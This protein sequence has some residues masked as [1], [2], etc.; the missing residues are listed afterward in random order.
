LW[1]FENTA[2]V[3]AG[4][5]A[6]KPDVDFKNR[7]LLFARRTPTPFT[8]PTPNGTTFDRLTHRLVY[9]RN[10]GLSLFDR[11]WDGTDLDLDVRPVV[12]GVFWDCVTATTR[13]GVTCSARVHRVH[14]GM[15]FVPE[16]VHQ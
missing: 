9:D 7:V 16:L 14:F 12:D 15:I 8:T 6:R 5:N 3:I 13:Y 11:Y 4:P 1:L 10:S 2:H